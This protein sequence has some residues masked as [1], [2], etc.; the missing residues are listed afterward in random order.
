MFW[1]LRPTCRLIMCRISTVYIEKKWIMIVRDRK[2]KAKRK[3]AKTR[4]E[5]RPAVETH[6]ILWG[7]RATKVWTHT[8]LRDGRSRKPETPNH[9]L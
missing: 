6:T 3:T 1:S 4:L 2:K 7:W 9:I 8:I 5:T